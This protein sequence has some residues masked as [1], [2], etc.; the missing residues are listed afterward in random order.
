MRIT[1]V[2]AFPHRVIAQGI[3]T[4]RVSV[5]GITLDLRHV[6]KKPVAGHGHLQYYL[7]KVPKDAHSKADLKHSFIAAVA[8]PLF[9]FNL[10]ASRVKIGRGKHKVIVALAKNN[11]VLYKAPTAAVTITVR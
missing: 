1:S 2:K 10:R 11:Y 8:T 4:F 9:D 7:D 3:V 6:G 5:K